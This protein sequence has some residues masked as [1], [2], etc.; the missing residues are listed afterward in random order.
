VFWISAR[1][2]FFSFMAE[3]RGAEVLAVDSMA[4]HPTGFETAASLK[5]EASSFTAG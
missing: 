1:D 4:P 3:D 2:G 5:Q